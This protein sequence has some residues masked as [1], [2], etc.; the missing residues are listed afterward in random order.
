M[1]KQ[2]QVIFIHNFVGNQM[3]QDPNELWSFHWGI[4]VKICDI[5]QAKS[6]IRRGNGA[7]EEALG[8]F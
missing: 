6:D 5:H 1:D 2:C 7:V 3:G 8:G 4:Q